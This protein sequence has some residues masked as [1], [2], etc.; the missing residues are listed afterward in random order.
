MMKLLKFRV[1]NFRSVEDSGWIETDSVTAL[2]GTNES[3]KTNLLVPLWKLKPAKDGAIN[4]IADY[5]R[6]S[7]NEIRTATHK[8]IFIQARFELS[9]GL[10]KQ[11]AQVTDSTEEEVRVAVVKRDL[12]GNYSIE[13]P[14]ASPVPARHVLKANVA[15]VRADAKATII[16]LTVDP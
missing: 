9:D 5:P 6:K 3:G 2:I 14:N 1:T 12:G 16:T 4:A 7:Y 13:L 11:I 10:A 15:R 8:P